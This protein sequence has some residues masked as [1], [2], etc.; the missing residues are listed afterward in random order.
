MPGWQGALVDVDVISMSA[1]KSAQKTVVGCGDTD[2]SLQDQLIG[3]GTLEQ[4]NVQG[5]CCSEGM[6]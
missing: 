4:R 3:A 1:C 6:K 2:P 5:T